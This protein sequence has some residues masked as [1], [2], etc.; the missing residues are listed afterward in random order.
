MGITEET[1]REGYQEAK[2]KSPTRCMMIYTYLTDH[3]PCTAEEIKEALGFSEMNA[4]RPRLTE[5][6]YAGLIKTSGKRKSKSG[7]NTAL[8]EVVKKPQL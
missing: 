2:K 8:W 4:V 5:R 1:R 6:C 7:V 3:G